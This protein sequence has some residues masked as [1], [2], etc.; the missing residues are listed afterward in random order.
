MSSSN[1]EYLYTYFSWFLILV[2]GNGPSEKHL[3][4]KPGNISTQVLGIMR[5]IKLYKSVID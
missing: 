2:Y 5:T 3:R 4:H 1:K